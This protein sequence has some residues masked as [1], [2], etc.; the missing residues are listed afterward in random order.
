[1][2]G[3]VGYH[4]FDGMLSHKIHTCWKNTL[5]FNYTHFVTYFCFYLVV[6]CTAH[7]HHQRSSW[8]DLA[9][10][11][12]QLNLPKYKTKHGWHW[13]IGRFK[14][15]LEQILS[16]VP[17]FSLPLSS[18]E[19][20]NVCEELVIKLND[21]VGLLSE[22]IADLSSGERGLRYGSCYLLGRLM[23]HSVLKT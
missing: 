15:R 22:V 11:Y 2:F 6:S 5:A 9:V 7:E 21:D 4:I 14:S 8:W 20:G 3:R 10:F 23:E 18:P 19:L 13:I 12:H 17:C 16:L 1:M